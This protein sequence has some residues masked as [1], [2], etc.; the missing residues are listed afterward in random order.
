MEEKQ[1]TL[2]NKLDILFENMAEKC[3]SE[4]QYKTSEK[5]KQLASSFKKIDSLEKVEDNE[6]FFLKMKELS[7]ELIKITHPELH[8]ISM[9][10]WARLSSNLKNAMMISNMTDIWLF[11]YTLGIIELNCLDSLYHWTIK[12]R[13]QNREVK[14]VINTDT[15]NNSTMQELSEKLLAVEGELKNISNYTINTVYTIYYCE[16]DTIIDLWVEEMFANVNIEFIH[17][18]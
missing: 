10:F 11:L 9:R 18:K 5:M 1:V 17:V 7:K 12:Y 6:E 4:T 14:L 16:E 13:V 8:N 3:S 15:L 2:K